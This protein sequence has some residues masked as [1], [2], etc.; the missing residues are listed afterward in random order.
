MIDIRLRL[1]HEYGSLAKEAIR[2]FK[3]SE[4]QATRNKVA[5]LMSA[6]WLQNG[7]EHRLAFEGP[8]RH[9]T[10]SLLMYTLISITLDA[11]RFP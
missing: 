5:N 10:L 3:L 7:A 1:P 2:S 4:P 8:P 11:T 9:P 6:Y